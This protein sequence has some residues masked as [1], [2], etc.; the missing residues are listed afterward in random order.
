MPMYIKCPRCLSFSVCIKSNSEN[1]SEHFAP[2]VSNIFRFYLVAMFLTL[3]QV[4]IS[5]TLF[6]PFLK[7]PVHLF[8]IGKQQTAISCDTSREKKSKNDIDAVRL[9]K[10]ECAMQVRCVCLAPQVNRNRW[11]L[12][13]ASTFQSI[14]FQPLDLAS[15]EIHWTKIV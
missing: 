11:T 5:C 7:R 3:S 4:C 12:L 14:V 8:W 10:N 6:V 13:L 15:I 9:Y 2:S 1:Y